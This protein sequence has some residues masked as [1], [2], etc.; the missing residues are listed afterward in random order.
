MNESIGVVS[1]SETLPIRMN[2]HDSFVLYVITIDFVV[3]G[4]KVRRMIKYQH[5]HG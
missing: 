2:V 3:N 5:Q 1:I 4:C